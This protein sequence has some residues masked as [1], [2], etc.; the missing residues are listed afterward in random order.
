MQT[1]GIARILTFNINDFK[2]YP[3]TL[4]CPTTL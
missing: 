2:R 4:I 3:I 1:Y